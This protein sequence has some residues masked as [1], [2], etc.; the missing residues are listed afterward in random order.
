MRVFVL[1]VSVTLL[2]GCGQ[3][4]PT[5]AP[6]QTAPTQ[7][8]AKPT[9]PP[10]AATTTGAATTGA[11][12]PAAGAAAGP[13]ATP[14][15]GQSAKPNTAPGPATAAEKAGAAPAAATDWAAV[16]AEAKKEG[17]IV[18]AHSSLESNGRILEAFKEKY[19]SLEVERN[20]MAASVFGPRVVSEQR[21]GLY[22]WDL[23]IL[24]GF[25]T[26]ERVLGPAGALGDLRPFLE[27][28]PADVRDD[29]K[30]AGGFMML[31]NPTSPDSFVTDMNTAYRVHVNRAVVPLDQ[32]SS[33]DQL[34]D[35]RF[36]GRIGIY[37]PA[38]SSAGSQGLA[39]LLASKGDDFVR[40]LLFDQ[41][42]V[43][44]DNQRQVTEWLVQG[45]YPIAIGVG[46]DALEEFRAQGIAAQIESLKD[47][48]TVSTAAM[49]LTLL[50]NPPHPNAIKLFLRWFLSQDGQNSY[51]E[52]GG[53]NS[54]SRR[55]DVKIA[56]PDAAPDWT[57]LGDYKVIL[58]TPSG[59]AYL[60]KVLEI[61]NE[62]R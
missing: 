15:P 40:K 27:S 48:S 25:N 8:A 41:E 3:P 11:E 24:T 47:P 12:K 23:L 28:M 62:K 53:P 39:T 36:K 43:A 7:A 29:S 57:R 49:G 58:G 32:F 9:T 46:D 56:Y 20:G 45:R 1:V 52:R 6:A 18:F 50:N 4:T 2:V 13:A 14:T 38:Q 26:A 34:V 37:R 51:V 54:V 60:D 59:D 17:K 55:L 30:W 61:A 16:E 33:A 35:P 10:T 5:Q 19:P 31:R 21:Q 44:V 22:A 42:P